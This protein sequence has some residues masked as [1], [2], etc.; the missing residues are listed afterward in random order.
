M[1]NIKKFGA[2]CKLTQSELKH[3][4]TSQL[5][6][7][8]YEVISQRGFVYAKGTLPILLTA[9]LDTVHKETVKRYSIHN[10]KRK[11]LIKSQQG[12]GG[13][14]RCGVYM[15][16]DI[17]QRYKPYVLFCEDEEIGGIGSGLFCNT[18]FIDD[19]ADNVKYMI[20][21]DRANAN[22]AVFYD[23]DNDKFTE[24]ITSAT[25]YKEAYGTFS[26]ISNLMPEAGIAGVNLSCGYY[27]AHTLKEYVLFEEMENTIEV[28]EDLLDDADN[29]ERYIFIEK[30]YSLSNFYGRYFNDDYRYSYNKYDYDPYYYKGN[31]DEGILEVSFYRKDTSCFELAYGTTEEEAFGN[32]FI[33]H[34][35]ICFNDVCDYT[36]S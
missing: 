23:C 35:D 6:S 29:A 15:I 5:V 25:G 16:L 3:Y 9:H 17:I 27:N 33:D 24:Y 26:D 7:N 2:L 4:V 31:K 10:F 21:L 28:V 36:Y 18:S 12:I 20:E 34:P 11:H 14:D 13:D 1:N 22:D 30:K 8:G 32:F 19:I